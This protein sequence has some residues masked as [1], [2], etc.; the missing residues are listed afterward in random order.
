MSTGTEPTMHSVGDKTPALLQTG[1]H[2]LCPG[3]GEPVAIRIL[4]ETLEDLGLSQSTIGVIGI[5]CYTAFAKT[6]DVNT[7]QALHG[8]A[9]SV[10]TGVKRMQPDKAVFTLQGD[11]DMVNEGLQEVLHTAARGENVTCV[12]LNNGVFGE[13]G[14]HM[15]ATSWVRRRPTKK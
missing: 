11:G 2:D 7:V 1:E 3:C 9:P 6:L 12:L 13:T 15:T 8:R 14:G 5:G 10:A 4:L